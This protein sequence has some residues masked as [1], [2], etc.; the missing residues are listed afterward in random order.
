M[1]KLLLVS[2][3]WPPATGGMETYS[4]ELAHSLGAHFDVETLAL[5]G[6]PDGHPPGMLA[7]ALFTLKAMAT[8]LLRGRAFTNV[9]FGD[10]VLFP[11]AI[12]H[13]LVAPARK[14]IVV[15]Y[16][17]DLVYQDRRGALPAAYAVFFRLFVACQG[18]FTAVVAISR[19]TAILGR[20]AGL[21]RVHTVN[22]SLPES[23]LTDV[24][25][26]GA[27][28]PAAWGEATLRI[29]YFGRLV[30]RKGALWY[31]RNVVPHLPPGARFFVV[32]QAPDGRHQ[33]QIQACERTV[34]LGRLDDPTLAAMIRAADVVVMPNIPTPEAVDVEGF[35]LAAV[36]TTAIGGRLLAA[37]IDGITDAV[38]AGETGT[39][40]QAGD[41]DGWV[42]ATKIALMSASDHD[43]DRVAQATRRLFSRER[44]AAGFMHL[45][46]GSD[47]QD[48]HGA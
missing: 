11:A 27:A 33:S 43:P 48:H 8:C 5:P 19:H 26:D 31:A 12:C 38:V 28:F 47:G 40:V 15:V 10:L 29:L 2:R 23:A 46:C 7:Y 17:L 18:I 9:V 36:E 6:R 35:G 1:K 41:V 42:H 34:C 16:G 45:L 3:K 13:W 39:L 22:P 14:R 20:A 37:S 4:V 24:G 32:G 25:T 21:R 44:Q 30:P